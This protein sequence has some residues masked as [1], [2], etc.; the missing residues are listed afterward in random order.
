MFLYSDTFKLCCEDA[1]WV[2]FLFLPGML[3]GMLLGGGVHSAGVFFI[4]AGIVLQ[5]VA[6][7]LLA[8]YAYVSLTRRKL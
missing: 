6:M 3:L 5:V 1:G 2:V 8:R 4:S 7:W